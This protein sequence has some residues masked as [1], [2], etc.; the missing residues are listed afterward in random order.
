MHVRHSRW[1]S[2]AICMLVMHER[3][4]RSRQ[5]LMRVLCD[6]ERPATDASTVPEC[7]AIVVLR[8]KACCTDATS[9]CMC[10]AQVWP[11]P[12]TAFWSCTRR[13][14]LCRYVCRSGQRLMRVL[15][16]PERP[17]RCQHGPRMSCHRR[18]AYQGV[19]HRCCERL[20]V[21]RSQCAS[22]AVSILA[23]HESLCAAPVNDHTTHN[24][25]CI[26]VLT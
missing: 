11:K 13:R 14:G 19:F 2:T 26:E 23:M 17:D 15:C 20:H 3:L 7:L 25:F 18:G 22:T 1:A 21:R 6:P 5:R 16:D 8:A 10:E 12:A 4:C 9:G 24:A